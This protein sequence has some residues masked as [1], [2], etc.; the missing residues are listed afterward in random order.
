MSE[1]KAIV[2]EILMGE[3][4][5][6]EKI[7]I[8]DTSTAMLLEAGMTFKPKKAAILNIHNPH[9]EE[10]EKD[11]EVL[12]LIC[13]E[14]IYRTSSPSF[15]NSLREIL[16]DL[17]DLEAHGEDWEIGVASHK[18]KNNMGDYLKAYII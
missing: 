10:G 4:T 6:K 15:T 1:Y 12:M 18:S 13:E 16:D 9:T 5:A 3:F 14:G 8:K 17:T 7:K 11:Y 2:K